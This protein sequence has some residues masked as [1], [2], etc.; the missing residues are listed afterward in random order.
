[1][2]VLGLALAMGMPGLGALAPPAAPV[3]VRMHHLVFHLGDGVT[4]GIDDLNGSLLSRT[5]GAI[6]S[7]DD[8]NGYTIEIDKA[9]VAIPAESMENLLNRRVFG[10]EF[11]SGKTP[12]SRVRVTL[13]PGKLL[14]DGRLRKSVP[15]PFHL[16]ADVN[17]S[18][19]GMIHVHADQLKAAGVA[20]KGVL[21]FLGLKLQGMIKIDPASG[22]TIAGDDMILDPGLILPPPHVHGHLVRV[23]VIDGSMLEQYS[24]ASQAHAP[25]PAPAPT[26]ESY[27][28]LRGGRLHFGKLTMDNTDLL[29]LGPARG[30]FH[31][32][33]AHY[34]QQLTRGTTRV[35][36]ALGLVVHVPNYVE[37]A[38]AGR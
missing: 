1:M 19:D 16:S 9:Q 37:P 22:V 10:G 21:D 15:V 2:L 8:V 31:F 18:A 27:I 6:V 20:P 4:L 34:N 36:P 26:T 17:V 3:P 28:Y 33:P 32:S 30:P 25:L 5:P 35:T 38:G 11:T 7:L 14:L 23:T 12:V 13:S 29:M 24:P